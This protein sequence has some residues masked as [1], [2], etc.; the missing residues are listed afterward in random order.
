ML[1]VAD[2]AVIVAF[3]SVR[4]SVYGR[5]GPCFLRG[6]NDPGDHFPDARLSSLCRVG[7]RTCSTQV[8]NISPLTGR[9][10][11]VVHPMGGDCVMSQGCD[12]SHGVPVPNKALPISHLPRAAH[13]CSGVVLVLAQ[14]SSSELRP[15]DHAGR[16]DDLCP[17]GFA[18]RRA[19]PPD[20]ASRLNQKSFRMGIAQIQPK[21]IPP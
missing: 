11:P 8:L 3:E 5:S 1:S 15:L 6:G 2:E 19:W 7:T 13:P 20:P 16:R 10:W 21:P 17:S 4:S 18:H 12:E 9:D 14:V